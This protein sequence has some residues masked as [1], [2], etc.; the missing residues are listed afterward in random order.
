MI[1]AENSILMAPDRNG[2]FKDIVLGFDN[3]ED[4]LDRSPCFGAIVGRHA[5]R[6]EDA[7]FEIDGVKYVL[8]KTRGNHIH[9]GIKSFD[10]NSGILEL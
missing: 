6:I 7:E 3:I 9:G 2:V 8:D 1:M 5:N 10:K 4:Y